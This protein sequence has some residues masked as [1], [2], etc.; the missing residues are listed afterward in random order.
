MESH[1]G[2]RGHAVYPIHHCRRRSGKGE[3]GVMDM[4]RGRERNQRWGRG[5]PDEEKH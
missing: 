5:I 2:V 4:K 1:C 3:R